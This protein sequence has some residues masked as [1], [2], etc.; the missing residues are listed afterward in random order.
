MFVLL[1]L[2]CL[3]HGIYLCFA[4]FFMFIITRWSY[5]PTSKDV[6][7][8]KDLISGFIGAKIFSTRVSSLLDLSTVS[9]GVMRVTHLGDLDFTS[10]YFIVMS[11]P[12][13]STSPY[14]LSSVVSQQT[15]GMIYDTSTTTSQFIGIT[16]PQCSFY[17]CS[18][19]YM[20]KNWLLNLELYG[21]QQAR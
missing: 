1:S 6:G 5:L 13:L 18:N 3:L 15:L 7:G 20:T 11:S 2:H 19:N 14:S 9:S 4:L 17:H 8:V 10:N 16:T 12:S 21:V